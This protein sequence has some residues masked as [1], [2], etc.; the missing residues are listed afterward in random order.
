MPGLVSQCG[1]IVHQVPAAPE[2]LESST[3]CHLQLMDSSSTSLR[4]LEGYLYFG[5]RCAWVRS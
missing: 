3:I 4:V 1:P 5:R 2:V